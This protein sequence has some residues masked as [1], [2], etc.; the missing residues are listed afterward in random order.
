MFK[1]V[2]ISLDR[3]DTLPELPEIQEE[4]DETASMKGEC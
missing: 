4:E 1:Y 3:A 2:Q